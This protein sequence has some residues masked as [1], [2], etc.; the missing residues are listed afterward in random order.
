MELPRLLLREDDKLLMSFT[1]HSFANPSLHFILEAIAYFI[2]AQIYWRTTRN[3]PQPK[4][5]DGLLLIGFAILGAF[6][7]SKLLHILEHLPYLKTQPF[8]SPQ[9]LSGK[10]VLGGFLGGT[11]A[12]EA[13][14]KIIGWRIS[15]GDAWVLPLAVGL[16]IGR[17]GC[18][19]SG[20]EDLTYGIPT[21]ASWGWDYGDGVLRHPTS[22]YEIVGLLALSLSSRTIPKQWLGVRFDVFLAGYC[23]LRVGLE[24][25]KPPFGGDMGM[26]PVALYGGLTAIQWAGILGGLYF[27]GHLFFIRLPQATPIKTK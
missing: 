13:G 16:V 21:H 26:L 23:F 8:P 6:L 1:F 7:G 22:L 14:K 9:W 18:Q 19:L 27:I 3:Y 10:S 25:L 11:L 24:F 12:V 20:L 17:L 4:K 5:I 2:A 15:T